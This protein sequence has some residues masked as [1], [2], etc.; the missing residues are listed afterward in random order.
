M[1]NPKRYSLYVGED[2]MCGMEEKKNGRFVEYGDY[3]TLEAELQQMKAA[4]PDYDI[5]E[6]TSQEGLV[7]IVV[8]LVNELQQYKE[9]TDDILRFSRKLMVLVRNEK[10]AKEVPEAVN[11]LNEWIG[12]IDDILTKAKGG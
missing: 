9:A 6:Q 7:N 12:K 5:L 3:Q 11:V 10:V 8:G 2:Y 4:V 1:E